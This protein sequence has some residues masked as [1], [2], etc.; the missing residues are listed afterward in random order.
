MTG[1][2]PG[3]VLAEG[4]SSFATAARLLPPGTRE[5]VAR[6]YAWCRH[7]DDVI[8]GQDL[9][10]PGMSGAAESALRLA[11]LE[12][13]TRAVYRGTPPDEPAFRALADVVARHAIPESL[14]LTHLDGFRM[15]VEGRRYETLDD[16]LAYCYG[17]AGVVGVMMASILGVRDADTLDRAAD[18]G[19]A[20]Q[21]TNIARD[22]I[23]DA[24]A[25]RVYLPRSW[26]A[27]AGIPV[28]TLADPKL[29]PRLASLARR[30]VEAA[31]P[32]YGSALVGI[33]RLPLRTALAIG[34]ARSV[35]RAIGLKVVERGPAAWDERIRTTGAE[36]AAMVLSGALRAVH[37]RRLI[38][39][40]RDPLLWSRPR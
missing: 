18:L 19:L 2:D 28:E 20:F 1:A 10:R 27:E 23:D 37:A 4:S 31:E 33:G 6:L 14:P 12:E 36:K 11:E 29:R 16:L 3:A 32:Y 17:V 7:C 40:P 5:S 30:L 26:L 34:A 21:L 13:K 22:V 25:G 35:Y 9:G 8:D 39:Q 38:R 15:D 24:H